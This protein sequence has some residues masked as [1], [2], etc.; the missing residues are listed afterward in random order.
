MSFFLFFLLLFV[1]A[2]E[3]RAHP[4]PTPTKQQQNKQTKTN[5]TNQKDALELAGC[6]YLVLSARVMAALQAAPTLQ[7][8]NSGLAAGSS[9]D[10]EGVERKL[11][12]ERAVGGER[13]RGRKE[14][15]VLFLGV[16]CCCCCCLLLFALMGLFTN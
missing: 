16:V 14:G 15:V 7:G 6:D 5:K 1:C 10:E 11:S 8:Y 3:K 13:G 4:T 12:A 2:I 9:V